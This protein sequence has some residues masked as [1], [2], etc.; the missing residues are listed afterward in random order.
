MHGCAQQTI[1]LIKDCKS[2][3][4]PEHPLASVLIACIFQSGHMRMR[5][6]MSECK[7][8]ACI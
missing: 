1:Y 7:L 4:R 5:N 2:N 3:S 6:L 8:R